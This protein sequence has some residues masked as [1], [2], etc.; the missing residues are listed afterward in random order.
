MAM[1]HSAPGDSAP[2]GWIV[3]KS[4]TANPRELGANQRECRHVAVYKVSFALIRDNSRQI[5]DRLL[6]QPTIRGG[7][8]RTAPFPA[9]HIRNIRNMSR[10]HMV[11]K[12]LHRC[13]LQILSATLRIRIRNIGPVALDV[14]DT[15]RNVADCCA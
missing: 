12:E 15:K 4:T 5:R 11:P 2:G 14:A 10:M 6:V 3:S 7:L 9:L 1:I 13:G 8:S